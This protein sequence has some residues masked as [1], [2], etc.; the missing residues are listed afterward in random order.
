MYFLKAVEFC[1]IFGIQIDITLAILWEKLQNHFL[2]NPQ[3]SL[4]TRQHLYQQGHALRN[5]G[6]LKL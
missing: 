4:K 2:E 6:P 5:N 3:K 1:P